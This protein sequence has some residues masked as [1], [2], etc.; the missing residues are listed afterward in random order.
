MAGLGT[1]AGV[2]LGVSQTAYLAAML[3]LGVRLL[4][5]AQRTRELPE[6]FLAVHFLLCC[7]LG[8]A[9]QGGGHAL[10][11]SPAA[12]RGL[13]ATLLVLGH[14]ASA[15]GVAAI[16]CFNY[17][18]FRRGTILGRALLGCG[19]GALLFGFAGYVASGGPADGLPR[20]FWFWWL[21]AAYTAASIWTLVEPLLFFVV[22]RRRSRLGLADRVLV[23]RFL[24]WGLGSVARFAMLVIGGGAMLLMGGSARALAAVAGPTFVAASVA[25][26]FVAGAYWLAFFPPAA[27]R[28][29]VQERA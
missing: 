21:Y 15:I 20:G 8:Y 4:R 23:D 5:L 9:L 25:G 17:R 14:G 26:L 10:G 6:L 19:L 27:Y 11:L 7:T 22:L 18:V 29:A 13:V 2:V 1:T 28:R 24:L 16:L 12:P 3:T